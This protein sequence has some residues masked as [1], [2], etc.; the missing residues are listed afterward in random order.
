M[1]TN[2]AAESLAADGDDIDMP[3]DDVHE[4][5]YQPLKPGTM[6][7]IQRP[8]VQPHGIVNEEPG[9]ANPLSGPPVMGPL[10]VRGPPYGHHTQPIGAGIVHGSGP[11][12][13]SS[14]SL[15][16]GSSTGIGMQELGNTPSA[17]SRRSSAFPSPV[18]YGAGTHGGPPPPLYPPQ[19]SQPWSNVPPPQSPSTLYGFSPQHSTSHNPFASQ[20]SVGTLSQAHHHYVDSSMSGVSSSRGFDHPPVPEAGMYRGTNQA[21]A[22]DPAAYS[23]YISPPPGRPVPGDPKTG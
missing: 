12:V 5:S 23:S 13:E 17:L 11:F 22:T 14:G 16:S 9:S 7:K 21:G 2:Q 4:P 15:Q 10:P 18:D 3:A 19:P 8:P 20:Q 1:A 6:T